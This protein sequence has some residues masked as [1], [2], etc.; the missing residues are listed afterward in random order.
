MNALTTLHIL[1]STFPGW[2]EFTPVSNMH[3]FLLTLGAPLLIGLVVTGLIVGTHR[4]QEL[5]AS[6]EAAGMIDPA[7]RRTG[8]TAVDPGR[9]QRE[10]PAG[11]R[12]LDGVPRTGS[13]AANREH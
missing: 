13:H 10:V 1:E 8:S 3:M 4:R 6:N 7:P 12:E 11:D 5:H 9:A 2:P